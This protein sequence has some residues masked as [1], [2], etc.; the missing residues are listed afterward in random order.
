M[1]EWRRYLNF[2]GD[3]G[4]DRVVAGFGRE[5]YERLATIKAHYDPHNVFRLNHNIRPSGAGSVGLE[6]RSDGGRD[7]AVSSHVGVSG[8]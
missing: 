1:G 5:N 6:T 7:P 2:I 8:G 3:E 4:Q